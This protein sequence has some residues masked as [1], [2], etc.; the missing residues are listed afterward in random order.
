M[1][2]QDVCKTKG[3]EI[4]LKDKSMLP[5]LQILVKGTFPHQRHLHLPR[6]VARYALL[7]FR[8]PSA[9]HFW[10]QQQTFAIQIH[11]N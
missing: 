10:K 1:A 3:D 4:L 5:C 2:R 9:N 6:K 8:N 7:S 11:N